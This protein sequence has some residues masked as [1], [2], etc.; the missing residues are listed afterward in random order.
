MTEQP[1]ARL[2]IR[3]P[4]VPESVYPLTLPV[5]RIGRSPAPQNDLVLPDAAVSRAHARIYCDRLP[6]RLQDVGSSNGTALNGRPVPPNELLPLR[7]GDVIAIGSFRLTLVAA[8]EPTPPSSEP[9]MPVSERPEPSAVPPSPPTTL[10]PHSPSA[11]ERWVGMPSQESRWLQYLPPIYAEDDFLGRYLLIPEDLLGPIEQII[12][13]F[14][15]FLDPETCPEDWLRPLA[16][17]LG[18][19][20]AERWPLAVRR[21]LVKHGAWLLRTRGTVPGLRRHLELCTA[22]QIEIREN[23][24]QPHTFAVYVRG[25]TQQPDLSLIEGVIQHHCPAHVGYTLHIE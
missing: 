19:E 18:L 13:H 10:P 3:A 6:Y 11:A 5:V 4:D 7:D 12:A 9:E 8:P 15:L 20:I 14:D 23:A 1:V 17:W 25:L 22:G 2:L 16:D 21:Q 24:S